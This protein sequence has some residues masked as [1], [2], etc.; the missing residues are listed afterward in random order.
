MKAHTIGSEGKQ[1]T[2][3]FSQD[4]RH[5]V[6]SCLHHPLILQVHLVEAECI[7]GPCVAS[8]PRSAFAGEEI[9][10]GARGAPAGGRRIPPWV[11]CA[12]QGWRWKESLKA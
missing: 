7:P 2:R 3:G 1:G 9:V 5:L 6:D 4:K 10:H 12:G 11:S 8:T